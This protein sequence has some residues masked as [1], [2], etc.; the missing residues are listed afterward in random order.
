MKPS[1]E[2]KKLAKDLEKVAANPYYDTLEPEEK[3]VFD[4][5]Q[6]AL[7]SLGFPSEAK[8]FFIDYM[9]EWFR[10]NDDFDL[11]VALPV[12]DLVRGAFEGTL[13]AE[14]QEIW[15]GMDKSATLPAIAKWFW[16]HARQIPD[17]P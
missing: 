6:A 12:R 10:D 8:T 7:N 4:K 17:I 1:E 2:L 5:W 9:Q 15:D 11:P 14:E 3:V 13:T 16:D